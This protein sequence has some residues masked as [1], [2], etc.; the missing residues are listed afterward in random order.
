MHM[1][2]HTRLPIFEGRVP[3][4]NTDGVPLA[5]SHTQ[6]GSGD[7][8]PIRRDTRKCMRVAGITHL[9][10]QTCAPVRATLQLS[11]HTTGC[12]SFHH[13]AQCAV[14]ALKGLAF[15]ARVTPASSHASHCKQGSALTSAAPVLLAHADVT[16]NHNMFFNG[17]KT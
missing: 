7:I 15:R 4:G 11:I 13:M 5:Q 6:Q 3:D 17:S 2:L 8:V 14:H 10:S 1:T 12:L 9:P 16:K